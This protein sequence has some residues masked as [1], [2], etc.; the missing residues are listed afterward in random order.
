LLALLTSR[1]NIRKVEP[2][3]FGTHR[4]Q[5]IAKFFV[6]LSFLS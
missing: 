1:I 2:S 4:L 5:L 3:D 6:E